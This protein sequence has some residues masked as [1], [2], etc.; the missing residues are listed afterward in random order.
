MGEEDCPLV[1]RIPLW[2]SPVRTFLGVCL[3]LAN[4]MVSLT[5]LAAFVQWILLIRLVHAES[6]P[7]RWDA[8]DSSRPVSSG[9][10]IL[11]EFRWRLR[12]W[13]QRMRWLGHEFEQTLGDTEG[14]GSRASCSPWGPKESDTTERL[15]SNNQIG[16]RFCW[17]WSSLFVM[18]HPCVVFLL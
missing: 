1:V 13:W 15:S 7:S 17:V 3:C 5:L 16:P 4:F 2:I 14:Q 18:D 10:G 12:N 6:C 8:K 9:H 11:Q